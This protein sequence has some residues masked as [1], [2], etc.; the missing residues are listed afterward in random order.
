MRSD[1]I[2]LTLLDRLNPFSDLKSVKIS[3]QSMQIQCMQILY[4]LE[5]FACINAQEVL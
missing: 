5:K 3:N 4:S 2:A 1:F